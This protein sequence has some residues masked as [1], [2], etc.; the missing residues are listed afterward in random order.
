MSGAAAKKLVRGSAWRRSD[1]FLGIELSL[2]ALTS[3]MVYGYDLA[4]L[5]STQPIDATKVTATASF[6]VLCFFLMFTV[7]SLHQ[8]WEDESQ[9]PNRQIFFLGVISNAIGAGL[10]AAFVLLVKGV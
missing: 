8:D 4:K 9:R 1:F 5:S 6:T 10:L 2:G 7:M 3:A